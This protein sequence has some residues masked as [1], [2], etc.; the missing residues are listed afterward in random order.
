MIGHGCTN[1][2]PFRIAIQLCRET[3]RGPKSTHF[4]ASTIEED[5]VPRDTSEA[6]D[7]KTCGDYNKR[8]FGFSIVKRQ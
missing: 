8:P 3:N 1:M 4:K 6:T 5:E 2:V 7:Q